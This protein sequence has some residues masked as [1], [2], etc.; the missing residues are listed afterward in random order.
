M[1]MPA[2]LPPLAQVEPVPPPVAESQAESREV[3][4]PF[5][6]Y[7]V[8]AGDSLWSIAQ[9]HGAEVSYIVASNPELA[10]HPDLIR[11]GE[12]YLVPLG[13]GVVHRLRD[14]ESIEQAAALYGLDA[15]AVRAHPL[16]ASLGPAPG[17]G[18][19]VFMPGA[20]LP[21]G[22]L[23]PFPWERRV[24]TGEVQV[25]SSTVPLG[26]PVAGTLTSRFGDV[27]EV[28]SGKPHTGIDIGAPAGAAVRVT[29]D[30]KVRFVGWDPA[31]YG[32]YLAVEHT[33]GLSTLYAHLEKVLVGPGQAVRRGD[34]LGLVGN[35]GLSTGPHLHYEVRLHGRPVDPMP[36]VE[37]RPA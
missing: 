11:P 15:G 19:L 18:S 17:P 3:A 23:P 29:A 12:R 30:G 31:G 14:G 5:I 32:L 26:A 16:N 6:I 21:S 10:S 20:H 25:S 4:L 37:G 34:I 28:R 36:Y 22:L 8:R 24:I 7:E 13:P 2:D 9:A 33:G 35:S 1:V 27:D